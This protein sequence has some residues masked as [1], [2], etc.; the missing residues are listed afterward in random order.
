MCINLNKDFDNIT[1]EEIDTA[2]FLGQQINSNLNWK[3]G[4]EF[5]I[6]ELSSLCFY[7]RTVTYITHEN[8]YFACFHFMVSHGV[9]FWEHSMDSRNVFKV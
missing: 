7:M 4:I 8:R 5:V 2:K 6:F 9:I 3:T 1:S